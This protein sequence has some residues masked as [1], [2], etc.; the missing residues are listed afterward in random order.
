MICA[1]AGDDAIILDAVKQA[2][3]GSA[4]IIL[5]LYEAHGGRATATVRTAAMIQRAYR[6][7]VSL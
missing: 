2:E 7:N 1:W 4:D 6:T 3:D 5:R